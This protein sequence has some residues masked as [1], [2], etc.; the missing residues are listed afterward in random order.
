MTFLDCSRGGA[1][2]LQVV[3]WFAAL[4]W[5]CARFFDPISEQFGSHLS[6]VWM[7][8]LLWVCD[9][10]SLSPIFGL[11]KTLTSPSFVVF[12]D[13]WSETQCMQQPLWCLVLIFFERLCF[14]FASFFFPMSS[15]QISTASV[16]Q[17]G[18]CSES[19]NLSTWPY[20]HEH[21]EML[22]F[23]VRWRRSR[24]DE[25]FELCNN[26]KEGRKER[27]NKRSCCC[28]CC[29]C[30]R[31]RSRTGSRNKQASQQELCRSTRFKRRM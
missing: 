8:L 4:I 27:G 18:L 28:C 29:C 22:C 24:D 9:S 2:N 6:G 1:S 31:K 17:D 23:R 13:L 7:L 12:V 5:G 19:R 26:V 15:H 25:N 14:L 30:W 10:L 16:C 11:S 21:Q 3:A 20:D